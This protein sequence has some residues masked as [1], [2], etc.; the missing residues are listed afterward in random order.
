[1]G[2]SI[3]DIEDSILVGALLDYSL[4]QSSF[5]AS[6]ETNTEH[7]ICKVLCDIL[8]NLNHHV[9]MVIEELANMSADEHQ[10]Q[11]IYQTFTAKQFEQFRVAQR[12][13]LS[14]RPVH[15][16]PISNIRKIRT[17]L[18]NFEFRDAFH[19]YQSDTSVCCWP[20][21]SIQLSGSLFGGW[22]WWLSS[23]YA[24]NKYYNGSKNVP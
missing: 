3:T 6:I 11:W 4:R 19:T 12:Q 16:K 9:T 8:N 2:L 18:N 22:W 10:P 20:I 15:K 24:L 1:M 17:Q 13:Y 14:L 21:P 23:S 7:P 5:M